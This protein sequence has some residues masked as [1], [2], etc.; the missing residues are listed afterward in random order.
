MFRGQYFQWKDQRN[1]AKRSWY[2][3]ENP[4]ES[5]EMHVKW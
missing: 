1:G 5:N 2:E 4:H 3:C